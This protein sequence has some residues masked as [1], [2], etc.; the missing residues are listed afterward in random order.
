MNDRKLNQSVCFGYLSNYARYGSAENNPAIANS[1][2]PDEL[3]NL[4]PKEITD[5]VKSMNN[6]KH[7]I[8][9]YGPMT[10]KEVVKMIDRV[11]G[12]AK[13]LADAPKGKQFKI[14]ETKENVIY[15]A[16][17]DARQLYMSMVSNNGEQFDAAKEP[18]RS[19]YNEYFNGS[20]NSIVFQE[21]RESRSLAYSASGYMG[22]V[23]TP[24]YK[25][26]VYFTQIATQND[27]LIDAT[28]AFGEIINNMPQSQPAFEIAK[29]AIDARLRTARTIKSDI[30]WSWINNQD[31]G[32][33]HDLSA[34]LYAKL[35]SFT[36]NDIV[37]YQQSE[38]KDRKYSYAILGNIEDLDMDNL[39]RL[40]RIVILRLEDIFG[41]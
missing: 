38:V 14:A 25:P 18:V 40:G 9:Y 1:Y 24:Y 33:D 11:H 22:R 27:K 29:S 17:Y 7:R 37:N 2:K 31:L 13:K 19:L 30:A 3:A 4:D 35:P 20:M 34:D 16:P 23:T 6:Y 32:V 41:Y 26:Y 10:Q 21:M 12:T 36:L 5:A 28:T 39:K 15:I 8:V